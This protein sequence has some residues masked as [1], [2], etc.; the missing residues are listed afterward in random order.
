MGFMKINPNKGCKVTMGKKTK[1]K[2]RKLVMFFFAF[3]R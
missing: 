3:S 1:E 2:G